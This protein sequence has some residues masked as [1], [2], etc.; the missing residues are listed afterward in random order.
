MIGV[1]R[2]VIVPTTVFVLVLMTETEFDPVFVTNAREPLA[3]NA[4]SVDPDPTTT[5][6]MTL[7]RAA[8]TTVTRP[9]PWAT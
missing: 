3:F 2:P 1:V 6:P 5:V 8:F 9:D 4:T 7:F